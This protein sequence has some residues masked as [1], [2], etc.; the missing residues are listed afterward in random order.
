MISR[1]NRGVIASRYHPYIPSKK[2]ADTKVP[3]A[4][5]KTRNIIAEITNIILAIQDNVIGTKVKETYLYGVPQHTFI[6]H[7]Y[8]SFE[9]YLNR[10]NGRQQVGALCHSCIYT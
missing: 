4:W 1:E 2:Y 6:Q 10:V 9:F 3:D 7:K 8:T 5:V